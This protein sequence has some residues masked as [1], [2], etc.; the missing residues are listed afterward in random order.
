MD[1]CFK[2]LNLRM[3]VVIIGLVVL[4]LGF[5][6]GKAELQTLDFF[7]Q[8]L[9]LGLIIL[10]LGLGFCKRE[11]QVVPIPPSQLLLLGYHVQ[12]TNAQRWR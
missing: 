1:P 5:G 3:E 9:A 8:V 7:M 12:R 4:E 2:V 10:E 6:F 11:L